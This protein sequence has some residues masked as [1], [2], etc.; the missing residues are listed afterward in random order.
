MTLRFAPDG[1]GP[2]PGL[3]LGMEAT[4]IN[5][6]IRDV[7]QRLAGLGY[8]V[9]IPD[10]YRGGGPADPEDYDDIDAIMPH[11]FTLDFPR[12]ARDLIA[13][14]DA[15]RERDDVDAD[16][17]GYWG[18]CTGASVALLAA[19]LDRWSAI[20]VAF[21][22]SQPTF[23]ELTPQRPAH[24]VDLLWQLT[25]P[26]LLIYGDQD[27][28]MSAEQLADVRARLERWRVDHEVRVYEGAGHAF[29]APTPAFHHPEAD[30]RSWADAVEYLGAHL[31]PSPS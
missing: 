5:H 12:A 30:A 22:P 9:A 29:S 8:A 31:P 6:F 4:G 16:R 24:L 23:T 11:T 25:C 20:A 7:G 13:A 14:A 21:Y 27:V 18:Y 17:V 19:C 15:L 26:L 10:Y 28:I 2:H 1:P 3:V